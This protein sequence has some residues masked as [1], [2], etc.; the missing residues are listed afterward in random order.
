LAHYLHSED[1][2]TQNNLESQ[3]SIIDGKLEDLGVEFLTWEEVQERFPG[4]YSHQREAFARSARTTWMTY[5][6]VQIENGVTYRIKE[7]VAQPATADSPLAEIKRTTKAYNT[8][9]TA[10][11]VNAVKC[12]GGTCA[13][14][15]FPIAKTIYDI[16][17]AFVSGINTTT[18]VRGPAEYFRTKTSTT[19][20]FRYVRLYNQ[21]EADQVLSMI[22]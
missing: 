21:S 18:I 4:E 10:G 12:I 7:L 14:E 17:S 16:A 9:W 6:L 3:L 2:N 15:A 8:N 1:G 5:N 22:A 11:L 19:V 13:G 20:A